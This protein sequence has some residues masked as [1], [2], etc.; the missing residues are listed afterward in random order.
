MST[1]LIVQVTKSDIKRGDRQ[2]CKLCPVAHALNRAMHYHYWVEVGGFS[3]EW[4]RR[5]TGP[6][7]QVPLPVKV[8]RWIG[9]F[10]MGKPVKPFMFTLRY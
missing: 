5:P 7:K 9:R 2:N 8:G 4:M 6:V 3:V 10:D 1:K